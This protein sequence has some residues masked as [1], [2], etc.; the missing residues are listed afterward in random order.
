MP[1][2]SVKYDPGDQIITFAFYG[3]IND[4]VMN[5][6]RS[7]A[8][9]LAKQHNCFN[10]IADLREATSAIHIVDIYNAPQKTSEQ[11][12]ASGF[13]VQQFKR[14][15]VVGEDLEDALF[16]EAVARNRGHNVQLF[17]NIEDARQWL[18]GKLE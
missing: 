3:K 6:A 2:Y 17:R 8:I 10:M 12:A 11:L 15:L 7:E 16:F 18:S 9:E 5:K 4:A 13:K 1:S 14:A